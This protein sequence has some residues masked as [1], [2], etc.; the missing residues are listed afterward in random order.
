MPSEL[1]GLSGYCLDGEG[2]AASGIAI[3]L[4]EHDAV[5]AQSIVEALGGGNGILA[6]HGVDNQHDFGGTSL[7]LDVFQLF[8]ELLI[9]MKTTGGIKEHQIIS[10]HL[11]VGY[12]G[13]GNLN[14]V[15]LSHLEH[16][17]IQ[18]LAHSFQL[19]DSGGTV[20]VAGDQQRTLALLAHISGKLCTV[21]GFTC[22]LQ[23][24][25]HADAGVFA[26]YIQLNALA[27]HKS[28]ELL[29]DDLDDHLC[30]RKAFKYISAHS[31]LADFFYEVLDYLV[32]YVGLKKSQTNLAHCLFNIRFAE[33]AL[34]AELFEGRR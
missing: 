11:C 13:F 29:V 10:M 2:C 27:A 7:G 21:G 30:G 31:T 8:H 26:A 25:Q 16:R 33:A 5:Y 18:L 28:Y 19:L 12:C 3:Q 9:Y 24:Y 14:G 6:Y 1:D 34:A 17:D 32:A 4:G 20:N 22:T 23:T 15:A